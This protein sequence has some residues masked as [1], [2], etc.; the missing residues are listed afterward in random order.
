MHKL[1]DWTRY[2]VILWYILNLNFQEGVI[3]LEQR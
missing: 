1:L 3:S 2:N